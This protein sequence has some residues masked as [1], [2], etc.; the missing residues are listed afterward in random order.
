LDER[1]AKKQTVLNLNATGKQR[2]T[3]N[4][5]TLSEP[6]MYKLVSTSRKPVAE[7]ISQWLYFEVMP[8]L[9]KCQISMMK[10]AYSGHCEFEVKGNMFI[11]QLDKDNDANGNIQ[12]AAQENINAVVPGLDADFQTFLKFQEFRISEEVVSDRLQ[13]KEGGTREYV[14]PNGRIDLLTETEIIEVK[15]IS[16][17]KQAVGQLK[18]YKFAMKDRIR[19]LRLHVF[20]RKSIA[21]TRIRLIREFCATQ[22]VRVTF[23]V[24]KKK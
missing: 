21:N 14:V 5:W 10:L 22:N 8:G 7:A 9:R 23:E 11:M 18:Y 1:Y 13:C 3:Q 17:F 4:V 20:S 16:Q 6:G 24:F 12:L 15:H 2:K 19:K